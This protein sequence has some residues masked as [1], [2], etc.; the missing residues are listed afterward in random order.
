MDSLYAAAWSCLAATTAEDKI[1]LTHATQQS[2]QAQRLTRACSDEPEPLLP[3]FPGRPERPELV[4]PKLLQQRGLGTPRGRAALLHAIAHIEFN[5]INLAWDAVYRFRSMPDTYY[6]DWIGV[7]CDE[8]RHFRLLEGRLHEL[9]YA[10]GD[11]RP[12][13][14]CGK[15]R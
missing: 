5:A 11:F 2:W 13:M 12:T 7:A 8:A 1:A 4:P 14:D 3:R 10:Y 6:A 9:G 15:W